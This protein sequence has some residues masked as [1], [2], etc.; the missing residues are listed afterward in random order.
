[1]LNAEYQFGVREIC[2]SERKV[3]AQV[4]EHLGVALPRLFGSVPRNGSRVLRF[5][6]AVSGYFPRIVCALLSLIL[7]SHTLAE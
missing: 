3:K 7:V 6:D 4:E 1:M 2:Q 5:S